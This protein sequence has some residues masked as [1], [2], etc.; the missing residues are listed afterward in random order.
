MQLMRSAIPFLSLVIRFLGRFGN[1][2]VRFP[3]F[4]YSINA[5]VCTWGGADG[6]TVAQLSG[7]EGVRAAWS[8]E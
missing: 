2:K 8:K 7:G 5:C 6:L 4:F 1:A 3:T